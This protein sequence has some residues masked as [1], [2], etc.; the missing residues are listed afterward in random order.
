MK[1]TGGITRSTVAVVLAAVVVLALA[2]S[3]VATTVA[4]SVNDT[5]HAG[6]T[7]KTTVVRFDGPPQSTSSQTFQDI[8]A[9][10]ATITLTKPSILLV[11][12]TAETSCFNLTAPGNATYCSVR[13]L[14]D[15]VGELGP[16]FGNNF[17]FDS[18][19][20]GTENQSSFEGHAMQRSSRVLP[21][22]TYTVR[23]QYAVIGPAT[24]Q[25]DDVH[26]TVEAVQA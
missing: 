7:K 14:A 10:L 2:G 5:V 1:T 19:D 4:L 17:A 13:I 12:L 15:G 3:A 21:P 18:S 22:G 23:P 6:A 9:T 25:I 8:P 26:V 20:Q 24:F 16:G 11:T